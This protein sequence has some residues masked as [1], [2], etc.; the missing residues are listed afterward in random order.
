MKK[1]IEPITMDQMVTKTVDMT[2]VERINQLS[3]LLAQTFELVFKESIRDHV[4]DI[5]DNQENQ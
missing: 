5:M 1:L 4:L 2:E 3:D